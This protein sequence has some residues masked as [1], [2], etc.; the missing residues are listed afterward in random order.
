MDVRRFVRTWRTV[1]VRPSDGRP[2]GASLPVLTV[3]A[4][5]AACEVKNPAGFPFQNPRTSRIRHRPPRCIRGTAENLNKFVQISTL[6]TV[7]NGPAVEFR[8]RVFKCFFKIA[9]EVRDMG[10]R[11][12]CKTDR[13]DRLI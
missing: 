11:V 4:A 2:R 3:P 8:F 6:F 13:Q 9:G 1:Q 5:D 7:Q 10:I 12:S